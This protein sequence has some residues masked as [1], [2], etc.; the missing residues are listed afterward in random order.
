MNSELIILSKLK[1]IEKST[2][3]INPPNPMAKGVSYGNRFNGGRHDSL[4]IYIP[5]L[6]GYET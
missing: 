6:F 2:I 1:K 5:S 4:P 3:A